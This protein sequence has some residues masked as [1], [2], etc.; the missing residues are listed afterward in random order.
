MSRAASAPWPDW[1]MSYHLR[2]ERIGEDLRLAGQEI[3]E[4][5]HI[6]GVIGDDQEIERPRKFCGLSGRGGDLLALGE[7][8]GVARAKPRAES[9]GIHRE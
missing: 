4:E 1:I 2:P 5:A 8:I 9:A 3:R 6:V 7:T